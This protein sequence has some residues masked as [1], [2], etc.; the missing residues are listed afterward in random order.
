VNKCR[1]NHQLFKV[2]KDAQDVD[3]WENERSR[4]FWAA[5]TTG[6]LR[7][8]AWKDCGP[9]AGSTYSNYVRYENV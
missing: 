5:M 4:E 8:Q 7:A 9:V 1:F 2:G 3:S 6:K